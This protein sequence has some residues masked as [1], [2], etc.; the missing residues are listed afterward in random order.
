V[1]VAAAALL[2]MCRRERNLDAGAHAGPVG[3][4]FSPSRTAAV[5]GLEA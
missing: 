2:I 5:V 1:V 3:R 4:P